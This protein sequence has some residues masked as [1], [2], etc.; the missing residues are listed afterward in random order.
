L[1]L[2]EN[3]IKDVFLDKEETVKFLKSSASG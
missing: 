3:S 1:D 2:H